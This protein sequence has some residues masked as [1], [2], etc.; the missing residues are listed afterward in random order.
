MKYLSKINTHKILSL[1]LWF[2]AL[3]SFIVGIG[4]ITMPSNIIEYLGFTSGG[5]RFF[6]EQGGMFHIIMAAAYTLPAI[7]INKFES[8]IL[9]AIVV[10][11]SATIFL[12]VY[13][14]FASR[15]LIVLLSGIT[16]FLMAVV[17]L[18]VYILYRQQNRQIN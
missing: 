11:I 16:D 6:Q 18:L 8:L 4:L 1:I 13:Y 10:K 7:K 2:I 9:F 12:F 3:H 15:I 14:F 17:I 5:D